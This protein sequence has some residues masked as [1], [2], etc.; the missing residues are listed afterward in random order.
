MPASVVFPAASI[1]RLIV[2]KRRCR[3]GSP[4]VTAAIQVAETKLNAVEIMIEAQTYARSLYEKPGFG[5]TSEE[6]PED[7]IPH[8]QI[9]RKISNPI[10]QTEKNDVQS[11]A[12]EKA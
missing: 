8:I 12:Q 10:R 11:N 4:I 7:G 3:F 1:G 6:F 5:Q 2:V 9:P